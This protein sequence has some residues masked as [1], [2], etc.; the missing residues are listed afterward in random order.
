MKRPVYTKL[1]L[2]YVLFLIY[3]SVVPFDFI[4]S[5]ADFYQAIAQIRWI[6]FFLAQER[7][8]PDIVSNLALFFPFGL[9]LASIM[10]A[11]MPLWIILC[12]SIVSG[13]FMSCFLEMIQLFVS[14]RIT[15]ISDVI[16]NALGSGAG[17]LTAYIYHR[18][19]NRYLEPVFLHTLKRPLLEVYTVFIFA[20][21]LFFACAPFDVSIDISDLKA[22]VKHTLRY[23]NLIVPWRYMKSS[24]NNFLLF[25]AA[26]VFACVAGWRQ[27]FRLISVV[28]IFLFCLIFA[29]MMECIQ[30]FIVSRSTSVSNFF[31]AIFGTC[32]GIG[33]SLIYLKNEHLSVRMMRFFL[34][35]YC[36]YILFNTMF[37][38]Q[39]EPSP[40]SKLSLYTIIPFSM[41]FVRIN[42]FSVSDLSTQ[43]ITFIPMGICGIFNKHRKNSKA[44]VIGLLSGMVLE[45]VQ[46][47]IATRYCDSTDA[48]LAGTGAL[49]GNILAKRFFEFRKNTASI[50]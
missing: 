37:P 17:A 22:S 18:Y 4:R 29:G 11:R 40:S 32:S 41:Y 14:S 34:V 44:F 33:I 47:F 1:F 15:S 13:A 19:I 16:N 25:C 7:S 6:P 27:R 2:L 24:I 20:G 9:L 8:L 48:I 42:I 35:M 31:F 46:I 26:S 45:L 39:I 38:F 36:I 3:A 28:R 43:I 12:I 49:C 50:S 10:L 5:K 23:P 30:L 21:I